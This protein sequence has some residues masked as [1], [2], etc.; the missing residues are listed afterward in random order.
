[1]LGMSKPLTSATIQIFPTFSSLSKP[2]R[3]EFPSFFSVA[4]TATDSCVQLYYLLNLPS[5]AKPS[6]PF[7]T[8]QNSHAG[9]CIEWQSCRCEWSPEYRPLGGFQLLT[10]LNS[11]LTLMYPYVSTWPIYGEEMYVHHEDVHHTAH[12]LDRDCYWCSSQVVKLHL[13]SAEDKG[14]VETSPARR[15]A[16][17]RC[18]GGPSLIRTRGRTGKGRRR[19]ADHAFMELQLLCCIFHSASEQV[20]PSQWL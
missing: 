14:E 20:Q 11:A 6:L 10:K 17:S 1:M 19:E 16:I 4:Y 7:L 8:F 2:T 13:M 9:K 5:I 3:R 12:L 18:S 15:P